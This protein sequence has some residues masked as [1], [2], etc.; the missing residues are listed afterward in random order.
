[1]QNFFRLQRFKKQRRLLKRTS[2]ALL[3]HLQSAAKEFVRFLSARDEQD[4]KIISLS[5]TTSVADPIL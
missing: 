4:E 1:M 5:R 3:E 2:N